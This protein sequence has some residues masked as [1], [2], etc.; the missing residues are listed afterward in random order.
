MDKVV[1]VIGGLGPEATLDFYAKLLA[2]TPAQR[3]QDHLR[4]VIDSNPKVPDRNRAVAGEGDSP[5]PALASTARALERAG[6]ELLCMP[7]NTAHAFIADVRGATSLPFISI[8]DATLLEVR[9][10]RPPVQRV[11]LLTADGG[12][13]ARVYEDALVAVGL[14]A[15]TLDDGD[16]ATLMQLIYGVKAG[17]RGNDER[18]A[19]AA[20]AR[21]LVDRG[22]QAL[23]AG[24]TEVP[25]LMSAAD[26]V[27][28]FI[29]STAALARAVVRAARGA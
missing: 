27:I 10:L 18:A 8:I 4:V 1:G 17:R 20:L 16:Q 22:A 24:C 19:M 5:G 28:P 14:D 6:A 7:C 26:T 3:D 21:R 29:D 9:T 2:A 25:L 11:G 15:V 12:R 13:R 23:I